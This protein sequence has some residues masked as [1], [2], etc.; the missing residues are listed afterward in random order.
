MRCNPAAA[1]LTVGAE[2]LRPHREDR[3][4]PLLKERLA[5]LGMSAVFAAVL[6]DDEAIL[7][8][9][10]RK[11]LQ[12]SDWVFVCG[13]L[14]PTSDDR[15]RDAAASALGV[16]LVIDAGSAERIR[17][18]FRKRGIEMPEVNLRQAMVPSG[19]QVLPNRHGTAPGVLARAED[20]ARLV[21]LP[22]PPRELAEMFDSEVAPRMR[23]AGAAAERAPESVIRLA[24][25]PESAL[26]Q[27]I[28]PLTPPSGGPLSLAILVSRGEIEVRVTGRSPAD[29][30]GAFRLADRIA[31]RMGEAVYGREAGVGLETPIGRRLA[32]RGER[33]AV[34]ESLTGGLIADRIT[35]VPG[36]SDWFDL[37]IVAYANQAKRDLLG[38]PETVLASSGAVSE[39]TARAMAE[40]VRMRA[41]ALRAEKARTW[42]LAVTGIAGPGGATEDK[43][44]GLVWMAVAGK[45]TRAVRHVFP[46]D[47]E[48]VRQ[49]TATYALDLL[50]RTLGE[51]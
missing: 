44:V 31:A 50:R 34:A 7:A 2:L 32:D 19:A 10:I 46:G 6:P 18:R 4:T 23:E 45:K 51:R 9:T 5:R 12:A 24:G 8:E 21:L 33:V 49:L 11:A 27:E 39:E 25:I 3:N 16:P 13:G 20:G 43:P 41:V 17:E 42:G 40:G 37:G 15:T 47:R 36:A 29:R 22:G 26:E 1:I 14:G 28:G 35:S 38:V 48:L 30:D